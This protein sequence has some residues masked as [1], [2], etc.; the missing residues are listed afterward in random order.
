MLKVYRFMTE[1]ANYKKREIKE[2][3]GWTEEE[4]AEMYR[5]IDRAI[6][7]RQRGFISVDESMRIISE[8]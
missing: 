7:L 1:Y 5:D 4:K 6:N 3:E 8:C 2:W